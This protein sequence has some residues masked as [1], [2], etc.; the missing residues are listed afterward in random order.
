MPGG[1]VHHLKSPQDEVQGNLR[2]EEV[3][4]RVHEDHLGLTP[5]ERLV[6]DP[7]MNRQP[8]PVRIV[9]LA[10]RLEPASHPLR[11]AIPTP[12]A[13]LGAPGQ[14]VP[15]GLGPLDGG[16]DGHFVTSLKY[17]ARSSPQSARP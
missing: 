11:I 14:R 7:L 8:E 2:V 1:P 15:G 17:A 12:R 5:G 9:R 4:H 6:Q 13:H 10:H 3:A 16:I